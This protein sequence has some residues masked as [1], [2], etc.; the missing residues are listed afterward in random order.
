MT[1]QHRAGPP[2]PR[3]GPPPPSGSGQGARRRRRRRQHAS[4]PWPPRS[5]PPIHDIIRRHK[6]TY[7]EYDALKAW[8]IQVGEDGEWP[9]FLDVW[10]EHVVEEVANDAPRG[11]QGHH[12]GP[13]LRARAPPARPP[14]PPCRCATARRAPRCSSRARSPPAGTPLPGA[15]IEMW[16]ADERRLLLP[17][18][19]G[20]AR[21][22]PAR[23]RRRR[24]RGPLR[25]QHRSSRRPTRSPPTAPAGSSSPPPAGTPGVPPTST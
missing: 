5:S 13:V 3:P 8:L 7:D 4:T 1:T 14:T 12:R 9:L 25:D 11:Q 24:R 10:V 22:E 15:Q 17:V 21:V 18:R 6:V 2:L 23:H 20:P 16:H 19:P